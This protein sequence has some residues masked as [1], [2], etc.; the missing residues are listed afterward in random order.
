MNEDSIR[1]LSLEPS[2]RTKDPLRGSL[3]DILLAQKP[4]FEALSY[5]WRAA[6]FPES[7]LLQ[8]GYLQIT[9]HLASALKR[10][11]FP[12]QSR[13]LWIDAVCI[14]QDDDIE[15]GQQVALMSDIYKQATRVLIWLGE[16]TE[17]TR[18][19]IL[20]MKVLAV[21]A[22]AFGV[23]KGTDSDI[24]AEPTVREKEE[25]I[26]QVVELASRKALDDFYGRDW[27][28]RLWILEEVVLA[29][30]VLFCC[31]S[32]EL[33]WRSFVMATAL[34]EA[35]SKTTA[36]A[37]ATLILTPTLGG[38]SRSEDIIRGANLRFLSLRTRNSSIS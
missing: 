16:D 29:S 20:L 5:T 11:R 18:E 36:G 10:L 25:H 24:W 32:H 6:V 7:L 2:S 35:S 9:N 26:N 38:S 27:F 1:V 23:Q 37:L 28:T 30:S 17:D 31:G 4:H 33:D 22:I 34:L 3:M 19:A 13:L 21:T 8:G 12:H 15:K 14:D